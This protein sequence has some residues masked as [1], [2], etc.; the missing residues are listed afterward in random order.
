MERNFDRACTIV[1]YSVGPVCACSNFNTRAPVVCFPCTWQKNTS[2]M[3][4]DKTTIPAESFGTHIFL[5]SHQC[6]MLFYIP[7]PLSTMLPLGERTLS[8]FFNIVIGAQGGYSRNEFFGYK[9]RWVKINLRLYPFGVEVFIYRCVGVV[10]DPF[11]IFSLDK[12]IA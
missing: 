2:I 12:L 8:F 7:L 1:M 3:K 10:S 4:W 9:Y 11:T 5:T 6:I